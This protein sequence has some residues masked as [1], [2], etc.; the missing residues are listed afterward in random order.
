MFRI[1]LHMCQEEVRL[2]DVIYSF[3][4]VLTL[5]HRAVNPFSAKL[6]ESTW[7]EASIWVGGGVGWGGIGAWL[8]IYPTHCIS[9]GVQ[10]KATMWN[11]ILCS[12]KTF[13]LLVLV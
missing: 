3:V 9:C 10:G 2:F 8:S 4:H 5:T 13:L 11:S 6:T 7:H 1:V 12:N